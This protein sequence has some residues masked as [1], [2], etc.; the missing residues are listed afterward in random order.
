MV[1]DLVVILCQVIHPLMIDQGDG[2]HLAVYRP[3]FNGMYNV[4]IALATQGGL[5]GQYYQNRSGAH[6]MM[7]INH[8]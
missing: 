8:P 5:T 7:S 4:T 3:R 6:V 1:A 2:S